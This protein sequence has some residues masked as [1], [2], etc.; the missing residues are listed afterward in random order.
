MAQHN[1]RAYRDPP[2]P[3]QQ[4]RRAARRCRRAQGPGP[5]LPPRPRPDQPPVHAAAVLLAAAPTTPSS[6]RSSSTA[7]PPGCPRACLVWPGPVLVPLVDAKTPPLTPSEQAR[8]ALLLPAALPRPPTR[9]SWR[10]WSPDLPLDQLA[11]A[12]VL[13]Q[14]MQQIGSQFWRIDGWL[15]IAFDGSRSTAP[16][17]KSNEAA[18]CANYGKGRPPSIAKRSPRACAAR[19]TKRT[20]AN[21]RSR[22]PGSPCSGTWDCVCPGTGV[23]GRRIPANGAM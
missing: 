22:K 18:L 15:P 19:R 10:R 17:T 20:R 9:A 14:R 13:H 7:I 6:P 5:P 12:R 11:P 23:W 21:R 8:T 4:S 2:T 3:T 1:T 16:R